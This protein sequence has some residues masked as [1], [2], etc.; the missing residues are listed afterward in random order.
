MLAERKTSGMPPYSRLALVRAN[1][2]TLN[3]AINFL[4]KGDVLVRDINR[5]YIEKVNSIGP[6]PAPLEKRG[7]NFRAHL[8]LK[9]EKKAT[10]QRLLNELVPKLDE[11]KAS[12]QLTWSLDVDPVDLT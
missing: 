1:A 9:G 7:G 10:L 5:K 12:R 3:T 4:T 11:I 2:K 6:I 8:I